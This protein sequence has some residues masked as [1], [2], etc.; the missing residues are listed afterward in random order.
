MPKKKAPN[1]QKLSELRRRINREYLIRLTFPAERRRIVVGF[2]RFCEIV[3]T[4]HAEHY[5]IKALMSMA[6]APQFRGQSG[7]LI[8]TFYPR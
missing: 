7:R 4:L 8:V 6:H 3:G 1:S 2:S 5:A